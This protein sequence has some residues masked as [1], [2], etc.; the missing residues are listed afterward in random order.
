MIFYKYLFILFF[1]KRERLNTNLK[2]MSKETFNKVETNNLKWRVWE[3]R[4]PKGAKYV[5][6]NTQNICWNTQNLYCNT[7]NLSQ[8]NAQN[9]FFKYT[10]SFFNNAKN[11][12]WIL[13]WI[14]YLNYTKSFLKLTKCFFKYTNCFMKYTK[15]SVKCTKYP[16]RLEKLNHMKYPNFSKITQNVS[17]IAQN[18]SWNPQNLSILVSRPVIFFHNA[19]VF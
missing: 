15:G 14:C 10:K 4:W 19:V 5:S 16:E 13:S 2:T 18:V 6:R 3:V 11:V 7:Q 8:K 9:V 1:C 17:K 12:S